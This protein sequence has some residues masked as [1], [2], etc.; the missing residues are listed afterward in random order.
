MTIARVSFSNRLKKLNIPLVKL[1]SS[2]HDSIVVDAPKEYLHIIAK[3]FLD[4]FKDLQAN[5]KMLFGYDWK[6]PLD[7]EVKFGPNMKDMEKYVL[8]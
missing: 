5:I 2:V 4:V 7:C 8:T 1:V 3:L 6:V